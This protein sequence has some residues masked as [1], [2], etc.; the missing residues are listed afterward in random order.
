MSGGGWKVID[1]GEFTPAE[2]DLFYF[3]NEPKAADEVV[4]DCVWLEEVPGN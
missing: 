3:A 2:G 4:I 1:L